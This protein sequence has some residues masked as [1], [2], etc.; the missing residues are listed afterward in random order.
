MDQYPPIN[1]P[2]FLARVTHILSDLSL[3]ISVASVICLFEESRQRD[4][5]TSR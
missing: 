2:D 1:D 3:N 4:I 5:K